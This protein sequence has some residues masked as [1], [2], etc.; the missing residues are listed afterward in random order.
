VIR[1]WSPRQ[2][3][4]VTGAGDTFMAALA[5][6]CLSG[7]TLN[8]AVEFAN[9]AAGLAVRRYGTAIVD[10][11]DADNTLVEIDF[12]RKILDEGKLAGYLRACRQRGL[13]IA[14]ANGCFDGLHAGHLSLFSRAAEIADVVVV[15]VND[16]A[17]LRQLKGDTRPL[18]PLAER[19][20]QI[21][22]QPTVER[23]VVFDGDAASLVRRL[24]PDILIKG[25]DALLAG[26]VP[27]ADIVADYGGHVEFAPT[28]FPFHSSQMR[29]SS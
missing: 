17:S 5:V 19:L 4:D 8:N 26:A 6:N 12:Q 25:E 13:N 18:V 28:R 24:R 7:E 3:V 10:R 29:A 9:A 22:A 2:V 15:A 11:F 14:L 23:V 16:D 20:V 21:A 27:G 1:T